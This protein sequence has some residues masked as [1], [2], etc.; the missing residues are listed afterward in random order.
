MRLF[1]FFVKGVHTHHCP[2]SLFFL[3]HFETIDCMGL[4]FGLSRVTAVFW[5]LSMLFV[6][7][8]LRPALVEHSHKVF[9]FFAHEGDN[10]VLARYFVPQPRYFFL[11]SEALFLEEIF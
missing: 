10:F 6:V 3:D 2:F 11:I 4:V 9:E 1:S 5:L 8:W 7:R